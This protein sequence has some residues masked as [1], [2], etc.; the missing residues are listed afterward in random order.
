MFEITPMK[1]TISALIL[2][3]ASWLS[4]MPAFAEVTVQFDKPEN[5]TDLSL[6]S[7][8]PERNVEFLTKDIAKFLD[9]LGNQYLPKGDKVD[10]IFRDIDMAGG[11]ERWRIPNGMWTRIISDVYP[12]KFKLQYVWTD[13]AGHLKA[14]K[15]ELI[16][17]LNYRAMVGAKEFNTQDS[18]RYEKALLRRW[19]RAS[20]SPD[21]KPAFE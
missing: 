18:L 16:T 12:P 21:G 10:I 6:A 17:D 14:R 19:F 15:N 8:A 2:A 11:F 5:F 13:A 9:L 1:S 20:F 4:S 7:G 3:L